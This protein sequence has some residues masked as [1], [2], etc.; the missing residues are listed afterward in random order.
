MGL[1]FGT[2]DV[3]GKPFRAGGY[4][5]EWLSAEMSE[6]LNRTGSVIVC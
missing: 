2:V 4:I 5:G 3:A 6:Y 1:V